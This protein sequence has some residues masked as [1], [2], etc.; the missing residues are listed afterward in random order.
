MRYIAK[1]STKELATAFDVPVS[2]IKGRLPGVFATRVRV[3]GPERHEFDRSS[4]RG[5]AGC[6]TR[7]SPELFFSHRRHNLHRH[8]RSHPRLRR[9]RH[10]HR[11]PRHPELPSSRCFDRRSTPGARLN[12]PLMHR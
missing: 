7:G 10:P 6:P 3:L 5:R 12:H 2:T 4:T 1:M 11:Q 9:C 8:Y